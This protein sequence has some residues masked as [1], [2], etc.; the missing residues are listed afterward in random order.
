MKNLTRNAALV[1]ATAVIGAVG[2]GGV[3]TAQASSN[4]SGNTQSQTEKSDGDGEAPDATEVEND[5]ETN[6]DAGNTGVDANPNEPGHQDA[7]D[8][9]DGDGETED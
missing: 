8:A 3:M 7:S 5:G 1:A 2:I 6:D 9:G 4:D